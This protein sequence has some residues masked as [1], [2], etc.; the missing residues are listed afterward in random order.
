MDQKMREFNISNRVLAKFVDVN[1]RSVHRWRYEGATP[2]PHRRSRIN[3]LFE[4]RGRLRDSQME[5]V[6]EMDQ[7]INAAAD[8]QDPDHAAAEITRSGS[9][10]LSEDV[11][12]GIREESSKHEKVRREQI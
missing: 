4:M 2:E 11:K 1:V 12:N 6:K 8:G 5:D 7:I 9:Y 10:Q 3:Q